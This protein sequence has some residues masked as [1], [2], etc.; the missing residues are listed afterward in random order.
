V[1]KT[2]SNSGVAGHELLSYGRAIHTVNASTV[3]VI[4]RLS[5]DGDMTIWQKDGST[6]GAIG[7]AFDGLYIADSGVGLRFDSGG[8][9]DIIPCNNSGAAAD[10]SI[11]LGATGARFK[12]L[13]LSGSAFIIA[14]GGTG[15]A[16]TY[17]KNP[18]RIW[19]NGCRGSNGDAY[20]IYDLTA[21]E[22]RLT[23]DTSG[24]V[25]IGSSSPTAPLEIKKSANFYTSST[26]SW[27]NSVYVGTSGKSYT[28][29]L[30]S[31]ENNY[32][33]Q[34]SVS[35]SPV[36]GTCYAHMVGDSGHAHSKDIQFRVNSG[37]LQ[38]KNVSYSTGR[39]VVVYQLSRSV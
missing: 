26:S 35:G 20:T 18:D 17:H 24:N 27:T 19:I 7:T 4:N 32:S 28:V 22:A 16:W 13:Y 39:N 5:N 38:F 10:A 37:Y 34:W 1:G 6:V 29:S 14:D 21:D 15:N 33:Q 8:T 2:T 36:Y 12:D 3:Q 23:I 11:N 30:A 31:S 9:D 25:G